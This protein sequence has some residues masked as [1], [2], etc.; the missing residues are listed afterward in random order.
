MRGEV[1]AFENWHMVSAA[2]IGGVEEVDE[3]TSGGL[4][5]S[6]DALVNA[7]VYRLTTVV[8]PLFKIYLPLLVQ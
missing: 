1:G 4:R 2:T 7:G 6:S 5:E 8:S 3:F